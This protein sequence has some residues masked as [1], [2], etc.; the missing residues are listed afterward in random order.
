[1]CTGR[2]C[3]RAVLGGCYSSRLDCAARRCCGSSLCRLCLPRDLSADPAA[4]RRTRGDSGDSGAGRAAVAA[5]RPPP[6]PSGLARKQIIAADGPIAVWRAVTGHRLA[7]IGARHRPTSADPCGPDTARG[8]SES[9]SARRPERARERRVFLRA[10]SGPAA[11]LKRLGGNLSGFLGRWGTCRRCAGG[12][13]SQVAAEARGGTRGAVSGRSFRRRRPVGRVADG[14]SAVEVP[15][16]P[17]V[18]GPGYR[19]GARLMAGDGRVADGGPPS[20]IN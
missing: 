14:C 13:W 11:R 17:C 6:R 7:V 9:V 10:E 3:H 8:V 2:A 19:I 20:V 1:M 5:G 15:R 4:E 12:A 16:C 18:S